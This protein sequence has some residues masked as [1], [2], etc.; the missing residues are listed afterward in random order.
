[1]GRRLTG[2]LKGQDQLGAGVSLNFKGSSQ[3]GT[4]LGGCLSLL[5]SIFF[6]FFVIIQVY[7]WLF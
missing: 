5:T 6:A 2:F 7:A 1:M 4:I 3:F